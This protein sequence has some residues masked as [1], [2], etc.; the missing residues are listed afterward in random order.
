MV[1]L[2]LQYG[3]IK[4]GNT[5]SKKYYTKNRK[6]ILA[7]RKARNPGYYSVYYLSEENYCGVTKMDPEYRMS[8]HKCNGKNIED[9]R[10]LFCSEDQAEAYYHE[11]MFHSVLGMQGLL[12]NNK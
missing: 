9:W 3:R 8:Q 5:A 11:A 7:K 4:M 10:I 12:K 6:T 1:L 2:L